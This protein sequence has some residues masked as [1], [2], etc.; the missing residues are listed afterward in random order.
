VALQQVRK[1]WERSEWSRGECQD[2]Y[3]QLCFGKVE[4]LDVA[5]E[6][7]AVEIFEPLFKH[8]KKK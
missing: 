8:L 3:Y 5:F 1:T 6:E 7:I 4:P 2:P